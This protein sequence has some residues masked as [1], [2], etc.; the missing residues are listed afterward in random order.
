MK[1]S[2]EIK[3]SEGVVHNQ[4][5]DDYN[6]NVDTKSVLCYE[7]EGENKLLVA[8]YEDVSHFRRAPEPA[9]EE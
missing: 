4:E 9:D 5:C 1:I 3:D 8:A 6:Y 2:L 7:A